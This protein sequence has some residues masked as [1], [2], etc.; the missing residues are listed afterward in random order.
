[1]SKRLLKALRL[2]SW[3]PLVCFGLA[4]LAM[5]TEPMKQLAWR[6]LDWRTKI[7]AYFQAPADPRIEIIL[8]GDETELNLVTWPPDRAYHGALSELIS[9]A[10][11]GVLTWDVILDSSREGDG[12]MS[13]SLGVK[14]AME[15]GTQVIT[16]AVSSY[17]PI[18][19]S[20]TD[21]GPTKP[22]AN[23]IGDIS[24]IYGDNYLVKPFPLLR[25]TGLFGVVDASQGSDGIIREIPLIIRIGNLVYPS[26]ALQTVLAYHHIVADELKIVLGDAVYLPTKEGELRV[27]I[28]F[29]GK[30]FIN[31][32]FDQDGIRQDFSTKSYIDVLLQLNRYYVEGIQDGPAPPDYKGKIVF[33]GQ[34]VTGRADAGP[35]PRSPYA[36]LVLVHANV[37]NNIL[38]KDFAKKVPDWIV[39]LGILAMAYLCVWL[40]LKRSITLLASVSL[41]VI[42]GHLSLAFLGWIWWSLWFPWIGPF[43]GLIAS[44]FIVIGRRVWQDQKDKQ[45]IKGMFGSYVSPELVEKM[46]TSGERP[47]L[48]G[49]EA[50]ITAYFSDIQGFSTFSE[51]LP[52]AQ[53]VELMNEYL[54]ACTDI[55]QEEG[56]TLD[57]Y[58]GDAVVAMFGAPITLNEHAYRACITSQR[59]QQK[60]A[61]LRMKW[62]AEG[63]KWPEI[64]WSMQTRIGLN[65]GNCIVGNM[66][67]RTRFNYTMMGDDVNLAARMESGAK[68]WGAYTMCSEA[69]KLACARGGDRVIF[70]PL[71]RIVVKGRTRATLIY[72][73]V[74]LRESISANTLKCI[75]LF[76]NGLD[77]YHAQDWAGATEYFHQSSELEPNIPGEAIGVSSNPSLVYLDIVSLFK[78]D[79][80]GSDWD[81]VYV[82]KEK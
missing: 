62:R 5:Q 80:P 31:Y 71:G 26:L 28:S 21:G 20:P 51:R 40:A 38:A 44:Q 13:M 4:Y 22:V 14:A 35:T 75:E 27:P 41:L 46:I 77:C 16:G 57:K 59:V 66:G 39:W 10:G 11:A 55:V 15:R 49:H 82:M 73:I 47:Q 29:S 33:V 36:P 30:Y 61:E 12:D 37:V 68:S 52:P 74:G 1:M 67:S 70:R 56:G 60:L 50:N 64:V 69:T 9:V 63:D 78:S 7:R 34:T 76:S 17:E 6:T 72:E 8:F 23:I 81:G 54:T 25:E 48:G 45:E 42:V 24:Q 65:S 18:E 19:D 43:L 3:A 2:F 32:R 79:P 53:L 58:I